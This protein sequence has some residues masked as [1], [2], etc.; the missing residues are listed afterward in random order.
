M[1]PPRA[2]TVSAYA[3]SVTSQCP[4]RGERQCSLWCPFSLPLR[5]ASGTRPCERPANRLPELVRFDRERKCAIGGSYCV[6]IRGEWRGFA[7]AP[8]NCA[9]DDSIFR[10]FANMLTTIVTDAHR[11]Y[12]RTGGR[13]RPIVGIPGAERGS[14]IR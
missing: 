8:V 10:M 13:I 1:R 7:Q 9:L 5:P 6:V 14:Q 3:A 4:A 12:G 2:H 11:P